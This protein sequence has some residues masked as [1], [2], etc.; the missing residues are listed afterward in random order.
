MEI[1]GEIV[2][3]DF[4]QALELD[5]KIKLDA[6]IRACDEALISRDDYR[7]L[8][9][10]N[11]QM[12]REYA[13]SERKGTINNE[14]KQQ[15]PISTFKIDEFIESQPLVHDSIE[16][17]VIDTKDINNGAYRSITN[18]LKILVPIWI[19]STPPVITSGDTLFLK[20]GGD[21]RNVG[22]NQN[23]VMSTIC[24]LNE[25]DEILKP[26]HQYRLIL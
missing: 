3:F 5:N 15:I 11:P 4:R 20:L 18:I 9:K 6:I 1:N 8:T 10:V 16:G 17:I 13:I 26:D 21:G 25:K 22:R 24:L 14:M 7:R 2:I 12:E 19:K 23:H